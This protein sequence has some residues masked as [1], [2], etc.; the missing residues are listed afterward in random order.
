[1]TREG[2]NSLIAEV[3]QRQSE[4]NDVEVKTARGGTPKRWYEDNGPS[5]LS[6]ST[7]ALPVTTNSRPTPCKSSRPRASRALR[8]CEAMNHERH[9][10]HERR[11]SPGKLESSKD[12]NQSDAER[13]NSL[14]WCELMQ[15][16]VDVYETVF[17]NIASRVT[18][19]F[20]NV[21]EAM[22]Q[23]HKYLCEMKLGNARPFGH[24]ITFVTKK[25]RPFMWYLVVNKQFSG[26]TGQLPSKATL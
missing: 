23:R 19:N 14:H 6:V 22:A 1:M 24:E 18:D 8:Q 5:G 13:H 25:H 12:Q 20:A 11:N 3:Q 17:V 9:E 2:L 21:H 16:A 10:L 15:Q 26:K 4:L 7:K